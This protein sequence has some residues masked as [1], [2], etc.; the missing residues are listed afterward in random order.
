[1]TS[2]YTDVCP[3]C[4]EKARVVDWSPPTP[5]IAVDGCRC[6]AYFVWTRL[7]YDRFPGLAEAERAGLQDHVQAM[8]SEAW[9]TTTDGRPTGAFRVHHTRVP[10]S[11]WPPT[12]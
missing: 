5:W 2:M 6:G 9:I 1:M 4:R 11:E 10:R 7:W 3:L 8:N 12:A